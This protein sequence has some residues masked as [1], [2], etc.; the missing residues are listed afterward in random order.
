MHSLWFGYLDEVAGWRQSV[1]VDGCFPV[2]QTLSFGD[3]PYDKEFLVT[4][5]AAWRWSDVLKLEL[6][7][8]HFITEQKQDEKILQEYS[9]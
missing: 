3:F 9:V 6:L 1:W 7:P 4:S 2:E 5:W 8:L